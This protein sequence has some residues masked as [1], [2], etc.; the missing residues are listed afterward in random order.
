MGNLTPFIP[1]YQSGYYNL[2]SEPEF[3]SG[4]DHLIMG[5]LNKG[6][7]F[8]SGFAD[9]PHNIV[10]PNI[11]DCQWTGL[12]PGFPDSHDFYYFYPVGGFFNRQVESYGFIART[13]HE[14]SGNRG[15]YRHTQHVN[16]DINY[17]IINCN[18]TSVTLTGQFLY[19]RFTR[20][21]D[22]VF[23]HTRN[24]NTQNF[25][26]RVATDPVDGSVTLYG[27]RVLLS[28]TEI[29]DTNGNFIRNLSA[30]NW[31]WFSYGRPPLTGATIKRRLRIRAWSSTVSGTLNWGV[32]FADWGL[33]RPTGTQTGHNYRIATLPTTT[34]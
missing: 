18:A 7:I 16:H 6:L 10:S 32:W 8:W 20:F 21:I 15:C 19:N 22:W 24:G 11:N 12:L 17:H 31:V 26:R 34:W 30:G 33:N 25:A 23:D 1:T 13:R 9:Y 29:V 28:N 27:C 5:R 4:F 3:H 2:R 14:Q